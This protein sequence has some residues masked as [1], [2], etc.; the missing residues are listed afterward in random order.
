MR[1]GTDGGDIEKGVGDRR[2]MTTVQG[3]V[4]GD[5]VEDREDVRL[6]EK[7]YV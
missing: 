4:R 5:K 6:R 2:V 7:M 1:E 3:T